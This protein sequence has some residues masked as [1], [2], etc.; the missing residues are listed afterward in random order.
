MLGAPVSNAIPMGCVFAEIDGWRGGGDLVGRSQPGQQVGGHF[1][2]FHP[3]RL[4]VGVAAS[5]PR[6]VSCRDSDICVAKLG[7]DVAE[8]HAAGQELARI[9]V[10]KVLQPD[11]ADIGSLQDQAPFTVTEIVRL[12]VSKDVTLRAGLELALVFSGK[13][14]AKAT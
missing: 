13:C 4:P 14:C 5:P 7:R 2:G 12:E 9:G 10:P 8:L 3:H 11:V 6:V 1:T